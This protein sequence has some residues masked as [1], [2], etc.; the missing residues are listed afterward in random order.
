V[1]QLLLGTTL[2]VATLMQ[3]SSD[4]PMLAEL[5]GEAD[6]MMSSQPADWKAYLA[7]EEQ[8]VADHRKLTS[9]WRKR[10]MPPRLNL[11]P[12]KFPLAFLAMEVQREDS[13]DERGALLSAISVCPNIRRIKLLLELQ[14]KFGNS[15]VET[16]DWLLATAADKDWAVEQIAAL[17]RTETVLRDSNLLYYLLQRF[18]G[19]LSGDTQL[20]AYEF[21]RSRWTKG[22]GNGDGE[23]YWDVLLRIDVERAR[24]EIIPYF[25]DTKEIHDF[26]IVKLLGEHAGPSPRVARAVKTWLRVKEGLKEGS[27][28]VKSDDWMVTQLRI[29]LLKSDPGGELDATV[30]EI[31]R[32]IS[33]KKA[34]NERAGVLGSDL[35]LLITAVI[36]INSEKA[37]QPLLRYALDPR[38]SDLTQVEIIE[39]LAARRY[40]QL[41]SIVAKW[42]TEHRNIQHWLRDKAE[43]KWGE[44]GREVLAEADRLNRTR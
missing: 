35:D 34:Q 36:A 5:A 26:Y 6:A 38:V 27:K 13:V 16:W 28:E 30:A 10:G 31:D 15:H 8:A 14:S 18:G 25:G 20:A 24:K 41:P 21:V 4:Y 7:Q 43:Q 12:F 17:T 23:R 19:E 11:E 40:D 22:P 42:M 3:S 39:W 2:L 29:L 1:F 33:R 37:E 32:L 9:T 44:Y